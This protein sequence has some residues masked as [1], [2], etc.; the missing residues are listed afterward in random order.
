MF[1]Q[2]VFNFLDFFSSF[3]RLKLPKDKIFWFC[4]NF[5][6]IYQGFFS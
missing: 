3:L 6:V 1:S 4:S 5:L 2:I